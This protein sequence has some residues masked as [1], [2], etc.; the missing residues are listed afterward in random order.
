MNFSVGRL[1]MNSKPHSLLIKFPDSDGK[2]GI[3]MQ[4]YQVNQTSL[5]IDE[6]YFQMKINLLMSTKCKKTTQPGGTMEDQTS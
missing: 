5:L 2:V 4:D 3:M 1:D 6:Q